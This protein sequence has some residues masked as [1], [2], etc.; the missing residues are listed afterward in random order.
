MNVK[1]GS[2]ARLL[3]HGPVLPFESRLRKIADFYVDI[4][5]VRGARVAKFAAL[6]GY[7]FGDF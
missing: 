5:W 2:N 3:A 6:S 4:G 1:I 7:G